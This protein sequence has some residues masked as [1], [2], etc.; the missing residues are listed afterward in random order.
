MVDFEFE[1]GY[2]K[3]PR[4]ARRRGYHDVDRFVADSAELIIELRDA[5]AAFEAARG[6]VEEWENFAGEI[7][8][9]QRA[10]APLRTLI[11]EAASW[12]SGWWRRAHARTHRPAEEQIR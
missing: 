6:K 8:R 9:G 11:D 1:D 5:R 4:D 2:A 3:L 7:R 12:A 10:A